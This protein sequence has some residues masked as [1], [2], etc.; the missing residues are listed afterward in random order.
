MRKKIFVLLGVI[1]VL[2]TLCSFDLV[3]ERVVKED[4]Y[5]LSYDLKKQI[6]AETMGMDEIHI[7]TYSVRLTASL[8]DFSEKN[9]IK[10]GKANCVGYA[11]LCKAIC[12]YAYQLNDYN[13]RVNHVR[14]YV[15][16]MGMNLCKSARTISPTKYKNFVKDH[17][18]IELSLGNC[19]YYIDPSLY[20]L[21]GSNC[22]TIVRK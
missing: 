3:K 13:I 19:C 2:L 21:I 17:D 4:S 14:G 6:E 10:N 18:F 9:N 1:V 22:M 20:D 8:L 16:L 15:S 11:I 7:L 12:N 5:S